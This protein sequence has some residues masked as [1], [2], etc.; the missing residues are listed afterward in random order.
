VHECSRT[1][2]TPFVALNCAAIP[3]ELIES[4]LFGYKRG[5]FS[6]ATID[7]PGLFRAAEGGSLFLDEITEMSAATQSKLLRALQER[8]VRPVGSTREVTFDVRVIACSNRDP[9]V[10]VREGHLRQDL[11]YRLQVNLI[12]VPPLRE[13]LADIPLL[14]DH[15]IALFNRRMMR[16]AAIVGIAPQALD[17]MNRYNWPGNVRELSNA[18]ESAFTFGTADT[19]RLADLPPA[20]AAAAGIAPVPQTASAADSA[21]L[22]FIDTER[23]LIRRALASTGG[24]KLRAAK[25]LGVSR[26]RLYARLRRYRLD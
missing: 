14:T 25:L 19:I 11:Y 15:F 7:Y 16:S 23:D 9:Q 24:N 6:G 18:I 17:S 13:R 2:A 4:E 26:K 10:A 20:V 21:T 12:E 1:P 5:A 22:S 3:R 8:T